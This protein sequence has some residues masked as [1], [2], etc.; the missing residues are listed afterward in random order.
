MDMN[1]KPI[2]P[3][4]AAY[5]KVSANIGKTAAAAKFNLPEAKSGS[6]VNLGNNDSKADSKSD[7]VLLSSEATQQYELY[8]MSKN[9]MKEIEAVDIDKKLEDIKTRIENNT[10]DLSP[11]KIAAAVLSRWSF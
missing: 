3:I 8:K 4:N 7:K 2:K 5:S 1:L 6:A 11:D 9:V 10:Y